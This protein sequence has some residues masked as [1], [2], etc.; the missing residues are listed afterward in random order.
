MASALVEVLAYDGVQGRCA[1]LEE[2]CL[3]DNQ[4]TIASLQA[5]TP[6]IQLACNDLKDLDL[7]GMSSCF[8]KIYSLICLPKRRILRWITSSANR[9]TVHTEDEVA[10][11][12]SFLIAFGRCCTLRRIDWSGNALGPRAF[13]VLLRVYSKEGPIDLNLPP[14]LQQ[15]QNE[16]QIPYTAHEG[17]GHKMRKMSNIP[18]PDEYSDEDG[19]PH[20]HKRRGSRQGLFAIACF[21]DLAGSSHFEWLRSFENY[22][23]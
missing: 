4:I 9:I 6:I 13:E 11:W 18:D 19:G 7:S 23:F 2:L 21:K 15:A 10:I 14:E 5:L 3:K 12:E 16:V 8:A 22:Y 17:P 1:R 20:S